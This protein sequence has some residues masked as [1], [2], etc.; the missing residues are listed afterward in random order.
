MLRLVGTKR[1]KQRKGVT[2]VKPEDARNDVFEGHQ[3]DIITSKHSLLS[4]MLPPA[5]KEFYAELEAELKQICG[6]RYSRDDT[7]KKRWGSQRGSIILGNQRVSVKIPRVRDTA[8]GMEVPLETYRR[9]KDPAVFEEAILEAGLRG[10]SQR[11]YH[12]GVPRL[13]A[14]FGVARSSVSRHWK[15]ATQKK[16]Q[17]LQARSL[18]EMDILAVLIDGKRFHS[19]GVVIALGVGSD[20]TKHV[21]GIYQCSTENSTACLELLQDLDRRGL[22]DEGLLFIVDG[23]SGLNKAIQ[24]KYFVEDRNAR[25]AV[26]LRCF[27]HKWN[28]LKEVLS[29]KGRGEAKT[30]FWAL[31]EAKNVSAAKTCSDALE[32]SLKKHNISALNSYLEAK[33]DLDNLHRVGLTPELKMFFSTTNAIE[34]L[35]SLL[36]E[37]LR[38]VKRWRDSEHF[39]RWLATSCLVSEEKMN[40][41]KGHIGLQALKV[42]LNNI[43]VNNNNVDT[44]DKAI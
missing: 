31:R 16:L 15:Q 21:L 19:Q 25:R 12:K 36:E 6:D 5:V 17:Q 40:R 13:G 23:G 41:I 28:N 1:K 20:G 24:T 35:N 27:F 4:L 2:P 10:T 30:L 37:D 22:P 44:Y 34:S 14:S 9:F 39:Q 38:R 3:G 42:Y 33:D 32:T 18:V 8:S 26:R 29:E 7:G 43:C 11:K